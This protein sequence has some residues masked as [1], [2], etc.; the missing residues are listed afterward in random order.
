M[1]TIWDFR[2]ETTACVKL[3]YVF[4]FK[5]KIIESR[6]KCNNNQLNWLT[7]EKVIHQ[8]SNKGQCCQQ[9]N[10]KYLAIKNYSHYRSLLQYSTYQSQELCVK[11]PLL[12]FHLDPT[13]NEVETLILRNVCSVG[14]WVAP[15]DMLLCCEILTC[16]T[17]QFGILHF[18]LLKLI[19]KWFINDIKLNNCNNQYLSFQLHFKLPK[20]L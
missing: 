8:T 10:Y 12:K 13:V 9:P 4:I 5:L 17:I 6:M 20:I 1:Q 14:K 19:S 15:N 18:Y 11:D 3:Q 7:I 2:N 16:S